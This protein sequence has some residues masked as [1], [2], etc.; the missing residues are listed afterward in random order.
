MKPGCFF[1]IEGS[2]GAGK[3]TVLNRLRE[4][5]PE[6]AFTR[7]PGGT[8][9]GERLRTLIFDPESAAATPETKLLAFFTGR[10]ENVAQIMDCRKVG[11]HVISD[12]FDS[13]TY[14]FQVAPFSATEKGSFLEALFRSL[15]SHIVERKLAEP[16]AYIYLDLPVEEARRRK[17]ATEGEQTYFDAGSESEYEARKQGYEQFAGRFARP[18]GAWHVIDATRSREDV[19]CEV[20]AIIRRLIAE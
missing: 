9:L 7:E 2:D 11:R 19:F 13:S 8:P 3:T 12:R 4:V 17:A 18:S 14:A 5:Y 1:V 10:A 20:D 15:R 16:S 6:F